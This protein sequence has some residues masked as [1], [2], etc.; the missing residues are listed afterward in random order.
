MPYLRSFSCPFSFRLYI[1]KNIIE[2]V[3]ELGCDGAVEEVLPRLETYPLD[4]EQVLREAFAMQIYPLG[5]FFLDCKTEKATSVVSQILIPLGLTLFLDPVDEI[6]EL[7]VGETCKLAA[8]LPIKAFSSCIVPLIEGLTVNKKEDNCVVALYFIG[9]LLFFAAEVH[10]RV[11]SANHLTNTDGSPDSHDLHDLHQFEL[12]TA[13]S[14]SDPSDFNLPDVKALVD[15]MTKSF[16]PIIESLSKHRSHRVKELCVTSIAQI[17]PY[18][19]PS[20]VEASLLHVYARLCDDAT[21]SVRILGATYLPVLMDSVDAR[22]KEYEVLPVATSLLN[23]VSKAVRRC[24]TE[25]LGKLIYSLSLGDESAY[26]GVDSLLDAYLD[27]LPYST[28]SLFKSEEKEKTVVACAFTFPAVVSALGPSQWYRLRGAFKS[29]AQN[30]HWTVR[31]PLSYSL[32]ILGRILGTTHTM[33]D[34]LPVFHLYLK[35][36]EPVKLGAI[37]HF[38]EFLELLPQS[39]RL[40]LLSYYDLILSES[41]TNWRIRSLCADNLVKLIRLF[42]GNQH[43]FLAIFLN[44]GVKLS[45]DMV[46]EVRVSCIKSFPALLKAII[47]SCPVSEEGASVDSASIR[48]SRSGVSGKSGKSRTRSL[49]PTRSVYSDLSVSLYDSPSLTESSG[50]PLSTSLD[51]FFNSLRSLAVSQDYHLRIEFLWILTAL[52]PVLAQY[53][54]FVNF[55]ALVGDELKI[56]KLD[57]VINVREE[58]EKFEQEA[59]VIIRGYNWVQLKDP[60]EIPSQ[61]IDNIQEIQPSEPAS[62]HGSDEHVNSKKEDLLSESSMP[63]EQEFHQ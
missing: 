25:N 30:V 7:A 20:Q 33:L 49:S 61:G 35:D 6:K 3:E 36:L 54:K 63:T 34:L 16:I 19:S 1:I 18:L 5:A 22:I 43:V 12:G 45:V 23:D 55:Q 21:S 37:T 41:G 46:S 27:A 51:I 29:L 58:L 14:T 13:P 62:C 2:T 38:P 48:S 11:A 40:S 10:S 24:L 52:L 31:K 26:L 32:H 8:S 4:N 17:L 56:L 42:K 9:N 47:R 53:Q 60:L 57:R 39:E 44:I 28:N 59:S 15:I 50:P